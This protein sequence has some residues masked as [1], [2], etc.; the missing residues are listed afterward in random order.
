MSNETT[1]AI[2]IEVIAERTRQDGLWGEQNHPSADPVLIGRPKGCTPQRMCEEYGL[3]SEVKAKAHCQM[4]T[5][6]GV[7]TWP[8]I[9]V[10]EVSEA[11]SASA[12]GTEAGLRRELIEVMAVAAAWVECIDRRAQGTA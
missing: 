5:N 12:D 7:L 2:L 6:I 1:A 8:H 9:L 10:E 4:A 11:V 3:P